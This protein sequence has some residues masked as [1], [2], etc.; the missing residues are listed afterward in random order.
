MQAIRRLPRTEY[1]NQG[2][3]NQP[4]NALGTGRGSLRTIAYA[5]WTS[6]TMLYQ[7]ASTGDRTSI[8]VLLTTR[9]LFKT[10]ADHVDHA[11]NPLMV[12]S[13]P[14]GFLPSIS[15]RSP[16]TSAASP[17][18]IPSQAVAHVLHFSSDPNTCSTCGNFT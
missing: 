16:V 1:G 8:Y 5:T 10:L 17:S 18:F 12:F 6:D 15:S 7:I 3:N 11:N 2:R 4:T 14:S 9:Q 13:Y